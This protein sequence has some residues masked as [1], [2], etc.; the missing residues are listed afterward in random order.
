MTERLAMTL[1]ERM[2]RSEAKQLV[3][4]AA[5]GGGSL[6][7]QLAG[8]LTEEELD[9]ALDPTSYLGSAD[10]FIDRALEAYRAR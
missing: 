7:E 5:R 8:Q 10:A 1:A 9:R 3:E 2:G 6:R 4:E